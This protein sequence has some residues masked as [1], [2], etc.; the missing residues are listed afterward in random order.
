MKSSN[1]EPLMLRRKRNLLRLMYNQS[2]I[3]FNV[4]TKSSD[5]SLGLD[6]GGLELIW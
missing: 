6:Y 2:K 5:I 4:V 1:V 3:E